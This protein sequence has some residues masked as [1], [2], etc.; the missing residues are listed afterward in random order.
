MADAT[1]DR[2]SPTDLD[3]IV[4]LYNAMF[5]PTHD[6]DWLKR[7]LRG[8]HNVLVQVARIGND[9]VGFYV[10]MELKPNVHFAWLV[11][12]VPEMRRTGVGS[13]LM[14]AA[15]DWARTEGYT[16][17]RFE[18]SNHVRP[19]LHFGVHE[20]YDIVGIRWDSDLMTN[21][22]IFEKRLEGADSAPDID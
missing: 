21:L 7:R 10:G 2:L 13:Q 4:H 15:A 3:T 6:A 8:R 5:R 1:I 17:I 20:G 16:T 22:V 12:V 18:A 9:A 11:G 14:R 19:F